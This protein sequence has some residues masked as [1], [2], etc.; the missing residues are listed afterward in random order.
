MTGLSKGRGLWRRARAGVVA[1]IAISMVLGAAAPAS[2]ADQKLS[3]QTLAEWP[4]GTAV[5]N[6]HTDAA[7]NVS[8]DA[9]CPTI[10]GVTRAGKVWAAVFTTPAVKLRFNL[11]TRYQPAV[12]TA[13][14]AIEQTQHREPSCSE[15][16]G[17]AGENQV[18]ALRQVACQPG[19]AGRP[20]RWCQLVSLL[21]HPASV[22]MPVERCRN[23]GLNHGSWGPL[24]YTSWHNVPV[25]IDKVN[26]IAGISSFLAQFIS[27]NAGVYFDDFDMLGGLAPVDTS[28]Y[29]RYVGYGKVQTA[30]WSEWNVAV[31]DA[32]ARQLGWNPIANPVASHQAVQNHID[33]N[34]WIKG[35]GYAGTAY[36][37][38]L[39]VVCD[40]SPWLKNVIDVPPP[41]SPFSASDVGLDTMF[42]GW[43]DKYA[44]NNTGVFVKNF[45]CHQVLRSS[46]ADLRSYAPLICIYGLIPWFFHIASVNDGPLVFGKF[47]LGTGHAEHYVKMIGLFRQFLS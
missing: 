14:V 3:D 43:V 4:E 25:Q 44:A 15:L 45:V 12:A 32:W 39:Q 19:A 46:D 2:A 27:W 6:F 40:Y 35:V 7:G 33:N 5:P 13:K 22:D 42:R 20:N 26:L 17:Y 34:S 24:E 9:A 36:H 38:F 18:P 41:G 11:F 31:Y 30:G 16:Y 47:N 37:N 10:P 8:Q 28:V 1:V 21:T 23:P 29:G